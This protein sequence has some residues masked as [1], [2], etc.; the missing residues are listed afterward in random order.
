MLGGSISLNGSMNASVGARIMIFIISEDPDILCTF[1]EF[2][3]IKIRQ[4]ENN[5]AF[6][7]CY[8]NIIKRKEIY[9]SHLF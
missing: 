2:K 7:I 3:P 5:N 8:G 1:Q 9:P 6:K 4:L